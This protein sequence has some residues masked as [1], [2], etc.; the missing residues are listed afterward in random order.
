MQFTRGFTGHE[1]LDEVSLINMVARI[2]DPA[3]AR[4][5]SPDALFPG[6]H[7]VKAFN[8]FAYC[9]NSPLMFTDPDG[10]EPV[11]LIII[12]CVVVGAYIGGTMANNGELNPVFWKYDAKTF[13][14]MA[15]GGAVYGLFG[16]LGVACTAATTASLMAGGMNVI[17]AGA[18]AGL[19]EGSFWAFQTTCWSELLYTFADPSRPD[20]DSRTYFMS[21]AM[22]GIFGALGG[23]LAGLSGLP[24]IN[25][26]TLTPAG[27][28]ATGVGLGL[29]A[30]G[31]SAAAQMFTSQ[32]GRG[33]P[34]NGKVI[35]EY[36]GIHRE[37]GGFINNRNDFMDYMDYMAVNNKVEVSGFA[38]NDGRYYVLPWN[39]NN[40][41]QAVGRPSNVPGY[42]NDGLK[43]TEQ[44][45]THPN[46]SS[47]SRDDAV[48]SSDY[49]MP[50]NAICKNGNIWQIQYPKGQMVPK[51]FSNYYLGN[52]YIIQKR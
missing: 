36:K 50:V 8:P 14:Y 15:I 1:M 2:Y 3:T 47:I 39:N 44:F 46:S 11:T 26:N 34:N 27:K 12:I 40:I 38:L 6:I 31:P 18:I 5:L 9:H 43:P 24:N 41:T 22:G 23:A 20:A 4:F 19:V 52:E 25:P 33:T 42:S 32:T 48:Y 17:C 45:H 16:G 21:A 28:A 35:N 7:T 10:N 51:F 37:I 29:L 30:S 49:G 13:E